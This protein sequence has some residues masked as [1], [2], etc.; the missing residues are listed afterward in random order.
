MLQIICPSC[1]KQLQLA[2]EKLP[3]DKTRAMI[4]CPGC[5][6]IITFDIPRKQVKPE[7]MVPEDHTEISHRPV[8][9][10]LIKSRHR[11]VEK[12]TGL[13]YKLQ[14][15]VNVLG[16]KGS[17]AIDSG[18]KYI[19]RKHCIIEIK[20]LND[21]QIA[22]LYDDGSLNEN[23]EPSTNGTFYRGARLTK[24]DKIVLVDGDE[25]KFGQ[26]ELIYHT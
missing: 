15:G 10:S 5:Q 9:S 18:D 16:R 7:A 8:Q 22:V 23:G 3:Q 26:T 24:F 2:A 4:K 14:E 20:T 17:P 25:I 1:K 6:K 13:V 21:S 19:S 12:S 11:L